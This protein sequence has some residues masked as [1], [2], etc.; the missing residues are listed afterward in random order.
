MLNPVQEHYQCYPY[1]H[2]PLLASVR[3]CDTYALNLQAL[4]IRFNRH[5]PPPDANRI[6]LAGCGTFSPY[7]FSVANPDA[8]IIALDLSRSSLNRARLHCMLHRCSNITYRCGDILDGKSVE[9]TFGLIDSYGVLHHLDD[10]LE[11][12]KTLENHLLPNGIIRIMLYS[13]YARKEEEA[14]R[15]A[16]RLLGITTPADARKLL[17]KARSGSRLANYLDVADEPRT[18]FGIA[19]ALLHPRVHTYR[20]EELLEMIAQTGLRPLLFAHAGA[21]ENILEEIGRIRQLEKERCSPGNFVLYLGSSNAANPPGYAS[22]SMIRLNPCLANS[23]SRLTMGTIHIPPRIGCS[24]TALQ[25][26]ERRFLRQFLSPV[27]SKNFSGKL[28]DTVDNFKRQLF[29][30]EYNP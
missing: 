20:I 12:L 2:Y 15:H 3:R 24:N 17:K 29:L 22:N 30:T 11:G 19:D 14:I 8:S 28:A 18:D 10:P 21:R 25:N 27:Q 7:P 23:V 26:N 5:L 4:W 9:G 16:L 1:P 6:L 13:R